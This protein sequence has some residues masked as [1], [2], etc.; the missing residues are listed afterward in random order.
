MV[1]ATVGMFF[2]MSVGYLMGNIVGVAVCSVAG[3]M[4]VLCMIRCKR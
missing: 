2:G 3:S 1:D 4:I